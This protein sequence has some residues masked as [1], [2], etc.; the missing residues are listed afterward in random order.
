MTERS[1]LSIVPAAYSLWRTVWE[2]TWEWIVWR[3]ES[4]MVELFEMWWAVVMNLAHPK[5]N[6][7]FDM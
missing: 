7:N 4:G 6:Y 1:R 3:K 2:A 5:L